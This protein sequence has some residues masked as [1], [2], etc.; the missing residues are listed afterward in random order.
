MKINSG[1]KSVQNYVN[2]AFRDRYS[3]YLL[4]IL[5]VGAFLR[6]YGIGT[7]DLW[8]DEVKT[9][10]YASKDES[11]LTVAKRVSTKIQGPLYYTVLHYWFYFVKINEITLRIPSA[12]FGIISI[13]FLY[14][15]TS[16]IYDKEV[17]IYSAA[18]LALSYPHIHYSQ[19]GRTYTFTSLLTILSFYFFLKMSKKK[20]YFNSSLYIIVSIAL[21]YSHYYA[22]LIILS[23]NL[24]LLLCYLRGIAPIKLRDWIKYQAV[25]FVFLIPAA[26]FFLGYQI[27]TQD[28]GRGS[29]I[30]YESLFNLLNFFSGSDFLLFIFLA[31]IAMQI[32]IFLAFKYN[33]YKNKLNFNH[34]NRNAL[35]LSCW[36]IFPVGLTLLISYIYKPLFYRK[37]L[38]M[39][40]IPLYILAALSIRY[41]NLFK[42]KLI[43]LA[44]I[45]ILSL[46]KIYDGFKIS[47]KPE[48][49]KTTS[50]IDNNYQKGDLVIFYPGFM[51]NPYNYYDKNGYLRNKPELKYSRSNS[52]QKQLR[53]WGKENTLTSEEK[54]F[55]FGQNN[56]R[57]WLVLRSSN[58]KSTY[59]ID[60]ISGK[61]KLIYEKRFID[62]GNAR[63]LL[64][65]RIEDKIN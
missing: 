37:Y 48:W 22:G 54:N 51:A 32:I 18:I 9:L 5:I 13:V 1:F 62:K 24:Y 2:S 23:Q 33:K 35:L 10:W 40:S 42:I 25:I 6:F 12:V 31:L 15:L 28:M 64:F 56:E 27:H 58:T 49:T 60:E 55:I 47:Q 20:S 7:E 14:K 57:I 19:E 46:N 3:I 45:C 50:F 59:L 26:V 65:S 30:S 17:G 52:R 34:F 38:L 43:I 4:A 16:R 21:V 36:L 53:I 29:E 61:Y 63:F 41:I 11:L 44:L 39:S 8:L